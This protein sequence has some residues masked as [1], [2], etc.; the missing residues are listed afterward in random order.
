MDDDRQK[1]NVLVIFYLVVVILTT[2]FIFIRYPQ[3]DLFWTIILASIIWVSAGALSIWYAW[4]NGKKGISIFLF[5]AFILTFW[6][7][8]L[9]TLETNTVTIINFSQIDR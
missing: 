7:G 5:V 9:F 4:E 2:A 1:S 3:N 6:L 8:I